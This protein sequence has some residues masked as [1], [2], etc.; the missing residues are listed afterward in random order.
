MKEV[1]S[2][3][4]I[5]FDKDNCLTAPYVNEIHES[6]KESFSNCIDTFGRD[7]IAIISNSSGGPDDL[8]YKEADLLESKLGVKV[9]RHR[10]K[11]Y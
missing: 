6:V 8:Q 7:R 2:I 11:V 10:L 3:E 4:A 5:C 9:L 1:Q